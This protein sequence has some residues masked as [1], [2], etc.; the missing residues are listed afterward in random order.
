MI[1][2]CGDEIVETPSVIVSAGWCAPTDVHYALAE[3]QPMCSDCRA[4]L[5]FISEIGFDPGKNG[6]NLRVPRGGIKY[7]E[8]S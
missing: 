3:P 8:R 1:C 6:E 5:L 7:G 2:A 4:R